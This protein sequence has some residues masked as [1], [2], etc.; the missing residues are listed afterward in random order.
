MIVPE[1]HQ[2]KLPNLPNLPKQ[3][4][5]DYTSVPLQYPSATLP[6]KTKRTEDFDP[7][8]DPKRT[9]GTLGTLGT[10]DS[11]SKN[12]FQLKDNHL[13]KLKEYII[14]WQPWNAPSKYRPMSELDDP[15][16]YE[17]RKKLHENAIPS[18][19]EAA[20]L[21][22]PSI[23][24]HK[25]YDK[26]LLAV[27]FTK[28]HKEILS[29][30]G[31]LVSGPDWEGIY[32][33]LPR[34]NMNYSTYGKGINKPQ[35]ALS[36]IEALRRILKMEGANETMTKY[37]DAAIKGGQK[38][39]R[40]IAARHLADAY[41]VFN[42]SGFTDSMELIIKVVPS[43]DK[44]SSPLEEEVKWLKDNRNLLNIQYPV[45]TE[46][47]WGVPI[48]ALIFSILGPMKQLESEIEAQTVLTTIVAFL[49]K[50]ASIY[51]KAM[52][53]ILL[54]GAKLAQYTATLQILCFNFTGLGNKGN[55]P[56]TQAGRFHELDKHGKLLGTDGRVNSLG[57]NAVI[58]GREK[59][60]LPFPSECIAIV[61]D[62]E[63]KELCKSHLEEEKKLVSSMLED[64][65]LQPKPP[66]LTYMAIGNAK[67]KQL[68]SGTKEQWEHTSILS[69]TASMPS[70][71]YAPD[72]VFEFALR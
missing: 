45:L 37:L 16:T 49:D 51:T 34:P 46:L 1:I 24:R 31:A 29:R 72:L 63:L 32:L 65:N 35:A 67:V 38:A 59:W 25:S 17:M 10:L 19:A 53:P 40:L 22:I 50:R 5:S 27:D 58:P 57:L 48:L 9:L 3:S 68:I 26:H 23:L 39:L 62:P 56:S 13:D 60:L 12:P 71:W 7:A 28:S 55:V 61:V 64:L 47:D 21:L 18:I 2:P 44:V 70:A 6:K 30:I 54:Y 69:P 52:D 8:N 14:S 42:N 66:L 33:L 20:M 11:R 36:Y 43:A 15:A 4:V 41:T